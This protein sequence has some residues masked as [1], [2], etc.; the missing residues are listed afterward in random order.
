M[1]F[2]DKLPPSRIPPP[3]VSYYRNK[4]QEM[5]DIS[6]KAMYNVVEKEYNNIL[7]LIRGAAEAG[8]REYTIFEFKIDGNVDEIIQ[9]L[10]ND[11]FKLDDQLNSEYPHL[12]IRW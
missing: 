6:K 5:R 10:K 2:H 12:T 8:H 11:G 3:P 7:T 9:K 4:A 1:F